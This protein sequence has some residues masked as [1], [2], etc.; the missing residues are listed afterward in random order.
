MKKSS[1]ATH[2]E[3]KANDASE[4]A[5]EIP[6]GTRATRKENDATEEAEDKEDE[7]EN[8]ERWSQRLEDKEDLQDKKEKEEAG[9]STSFCWEISERCKETFSIK[10]RVKDFMLRKNRKTSHGEIL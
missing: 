1:I 7:E 4:E 10:S 8:I 5:D 9:L 6:S 3:T 2:R